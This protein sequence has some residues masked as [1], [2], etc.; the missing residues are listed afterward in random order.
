VSKWTVDTLKEYFEK[1]LTD[2]KVLLDERDKVQKE[3]TVTAFE[4]A[5]KAVQAA[6]L[7]AEKA[8]IKSEI[9]SDKRFEATNEFRKQLADIVSTFIPRNEAE[10]RFK[11]LE[12]AQQKS[13]TE[14]ANRA[15][16]VSG[17]DG[18]QTRLIAIVGSFVGVLILIIASI[19]LV[20][21]VTTG[22]G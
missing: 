2:L 3:G 5:D 13:E 18:N 19:A 17:S 21:S 4:A 8:V 22:R 10:I 9:A 1:T 15:G 14:F 20:L 7:A 6:L 12:S 16:V 11:A